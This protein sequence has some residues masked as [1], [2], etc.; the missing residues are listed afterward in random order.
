MLIV[1]TGLITYSNNYN[2]EF[3]FDDFVAIVDNPEVHS[4]SSITPLLHPSPNTPISGR[5]VAAITFALNYA[6]GGLDVR[7]YHL[8][9]NL[10]H[11]LAALTL[12]GL[13][14]V[15]L[16]LPRFSKVYGRHAAWY[17]LAVALVWLVHPMNSETVN[18]IISRTESLVSLFYL[19]TLFLAAK[20]FRA[21]RPGKWFAAA[22]LACG[23]GM[24]SKE[25]MVS[26]PFLVLL[27]DRL[28]ISSS[29]SIALQK[30]RW[31]Y[32][33]LAATWLVVGYY[34]LDNPRADSV[35]FDSSWLSVPDYFRTQATVIIHYLKLSFWPYPLVLD[36]QDWPVV[37]SFTIPFFFS[38]SILASL[39]TAT[40]IGIWRNA[41]WS[42][43]G[44]L[45]F[46]ILAP[47]SSFIPIITE[48]VS[49]RRMYLPLTGIVV[50]VV[51][52]CDYLWRRFAD[53]IFPGPR[54][55]RIA[56]ILI[57]VTIVFLFSTL[58]FNR[59]RD[60]RSAVSIW[61]D[62]V[63]KRPENSRAYEN[64]GK[65]LVREGRP[66]EAINPFREAIRL[67]PDYEPK[68]ELAEI[69]SS[70][71]AALSQAGNFQ[72]AVTML[73]R[74]L[75]LLPD[76]ALM[77]YHLGNA[78]LRINDLSN[79]AKSFRQAI[80]LDSVFPAAHGNLGLVLMQLGDLDGAE[81][82]IQ[83][84]LKLMPKDSYAH[85]I[86]AELRE[87]QGRTDEAVQLYRQALQLDP[88]APDIEARL[89]RVLSSRSRGVGADDNRH[90]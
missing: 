10:I 22:T 45:F 41:W 25:V 73:R 28:F 37:K 42:I 70:L 82:H 63:M 35:L 78:Y 75:D 17:G 67:Y 34:Q 3:I 24:A 68:P 87:Q 43:L 71:G 88:G 36:S 16:L 38:F 18:Y 4:L 54:A 15:T 65:A 39:G 48:I 13:V 50:L 7:G 77:H 79:A 2:G 60:Y 5:P 61:A 76:D 31:F 66:V 85:V 40:I 52:T 23:M 32:A 58:T 14:R 72:E 83:I 53:S 80:A 64:L 86:L 29:F 84:L 27:Y 49:E 11:I 90:K 59:N 6:L 74:A 57:L 62:N 44:V 12:C 56:F 55:S 8:I 21:E 30:H 81:E 1:L 47:T 69:Y 51:F 20:A 46:L 33:G 89:N 9:N 19:C 26:A